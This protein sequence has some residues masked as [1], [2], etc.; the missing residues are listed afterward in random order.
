MEE[1]NNGEFLFPYFPV[2]LFQ[3]EHE[4]D[5][6]INPLKISRICII[7]FNV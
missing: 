2:V 4:E 5:N 1:E 7:L 3:A 6:S